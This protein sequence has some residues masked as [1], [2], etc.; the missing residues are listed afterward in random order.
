M[1]QGYA[2]TELRKIQRPMIST[3]AS[4]IRMALRGNSIRF[5]LV[6]TCR[7]L[8]RIIHK[9]KWPSILRQRLQT[10]S[11]F[12]MLCQQVLCVRA[13]LYEKLNYARILSC[14]S[15]CQAG[16]SYSLSSLQ[17]CIS[18]GSRHRFQ[19]INRIDVFVF[20]T[21]LFNKGPYDVPLNDQCIDVCRLFRPETIERSKGFAFL[22]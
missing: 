7:R 16:L 3:S 11:Q 8:L 13:D 6:R 10:V 1:R 2:T 14:I 17:S 5:Q 12:S 21:I 22:P 15:H 4:T 18:S 9:S 19:P 20:S